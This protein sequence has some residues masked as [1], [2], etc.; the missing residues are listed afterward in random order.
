MWLSE[1]VLSQQWV[2]V[3]SMLDNMV[4]C[5]CVNGRGLAVSWGR[6]WNSAD[7][8]AR[9]SPRVLSCEQAEDAFRGKLGDE[10]AAQE[11]NPLRLLQMRHNRAIWLSWKGT[12]RRG[13]GQVAAA[14]AKTHRRPDRAEWR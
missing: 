8:P 13:D 5:R 4:S 1:T 12:P 9:T 7:S 6:F 10:K 11:W 2:D 3:C 14:D